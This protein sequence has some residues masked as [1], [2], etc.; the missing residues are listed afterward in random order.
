M[1]YLKGY[2]CLFFQ[3]QQVRYDFFGYSR[4]WTLAKHIKPIF[5]KV[6]GCQCPDYYIK[7][8]ETS[9]TSCKKNN[10]NRNSSVRRTKENRLMLASNCVKCG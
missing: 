8:M 7:T 2:M 6:K 4:Y 3:N 9:C 10:A 1:L 5:K